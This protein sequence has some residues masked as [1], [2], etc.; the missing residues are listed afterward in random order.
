MKI[1]GLMS[2]V[3]FY[4]L[5]ILSKQ[6]KTL[7]S[8]STISSD[9]PSTTFDG[10]SI[11]FIATILTLLKSISQ[12]PDIQLLFSTIPESFDYMKECF[13][14]FE[15]FIKKICQ[16][17][18]NPSLIINDDNLSNS[19]SGSNSG[20]N[21]NPKNFLNSTSHFNKTNTNNDNSDASNT[22]IKKKVSE[23]LITLYAIIVR[24]ISCA[25]TAPFDAGLTG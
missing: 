18:N 16:I 10:K 11:Y 1:H 8:I 5:S 23:L 2:S 13:I 17:I 24:N 9:L 14:L 6:M 7:S 19:S 20:K 3:S 22:I 4:P 15:I 12:L 25:I 21:P